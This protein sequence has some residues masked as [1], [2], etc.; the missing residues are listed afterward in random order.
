MEV[1]DDVDEPAPPTA[2]VKEEAEAPKENGICRERKLVDKVFKD[3]KGFIGINFP[4]I[5]L[6]DPTDQVV[7]QSQRKPG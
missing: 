2:S 4:E 6:I 5:H 7:F 1:E 3:E